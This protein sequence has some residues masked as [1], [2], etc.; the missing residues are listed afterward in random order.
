MHWS[1]R[2]QKQGD[3]S[4]GCGIDLGSDDQSDGENGQEGRPLRT[5]TACD[6]EATSADDHNGC[7]LSR[8]MGGWI[9]LWSQRVLD[10]GLVWGQLA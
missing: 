8:W 1:R 6:R 7:V 4:K 2:A 9:G 10:A 5:V 3:L